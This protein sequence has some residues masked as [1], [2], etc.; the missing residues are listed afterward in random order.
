[1][2]PELEHLQQITRRNFLKNAGQFSLGALALANLI[3]RDSCSAA[4]Q[5]LNPLA[6]RKPHYKPKVNRVIYLHMSGGPPHLDLF[7][8]KPELVKWNEKPC[9]D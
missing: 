1:M 6:S 9:P 3:G 2:T 4:D 7:D 5:A 8:Y